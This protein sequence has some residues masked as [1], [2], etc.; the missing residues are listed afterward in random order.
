MEFW[1][2]EQEGVVLEGGRGGKQWRS[3]GGGG[4]GDGVA[5]W[6]EGERG[7]RAG[8]ANEET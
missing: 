8:G 1:R 3:G 5:G 2:G 6:G 7:N 4:V